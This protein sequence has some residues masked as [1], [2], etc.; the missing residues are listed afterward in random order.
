MTQQ[1]I[2]DKDREQRDENAAFI[3]SLVNWFRS[4]DWR[5][6]N[7]RAD[8]WLPIESAPRDGSYFLGIKAGFIA[9]VAHWDDELNQFL[10][11][12]P[13]DYAEYAHYEA[14]LDVSGPWE[15][16]HWQPLPT[17][18]AAQAVRYDSTKEST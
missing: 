6:A 10:T 1:Q 15:P 2:G 4:Q 11:T 13:D 3:A 14:Y 5:A 9:G 18:P 7:A 17:P 12:E 16:T 8:E